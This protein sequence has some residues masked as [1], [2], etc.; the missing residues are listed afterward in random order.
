MPQVRPLKKKEKK[1]NIPSAYYILGT[2]ESGERGVKYQEERTELVT[3]DSRSQVLSVSAT[4][5]S[6]RTVEVRRGQQRAAG[7]EGTQTS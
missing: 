5:H 2:W 3:R 7:L 1:K 6:I 4:P